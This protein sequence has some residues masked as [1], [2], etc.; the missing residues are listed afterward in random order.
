MVT[1]TN[2]EGK[3]PIGQ[4]SP[5]AAS[6]AT[7]P[8]RYLWLGLIILGYIGVYLCRKNFSVA[9][10]LLQEK[11]NASRTEIGWVASYSTVA[12]A[13]GKFIF[14]VLVDRVGG[15]LGFFASLS[16]VAAMG[17]AGGFA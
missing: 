4:S 11:F 12:Y 10:P 6:L 1:D 13:L 17:I 2:T 5:E 8:Q 7:A 9:V 16:A 3:P 15:R 14:G